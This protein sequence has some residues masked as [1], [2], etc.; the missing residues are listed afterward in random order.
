M[1]S[2]I[3]TLFICDFLFYI[4][5]SSLNF[6]LFYYVFISILVAL[7]LKIKFELVIYDLKFNKSYSL[8]HTALIIFIS[9]QYFL[10]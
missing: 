5:K 9:V 6:E 7:L 2:Q 10:I 1:P 4:L 3:L 8:K